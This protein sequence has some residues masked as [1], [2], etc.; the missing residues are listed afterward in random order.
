MP[1]PG[2]ECRA[3]SPQLATA[4]GLG[5]A[6]PVAAASARMPLAVVYQSVQNMLVWPGTLSHSR[7]YRRDKMACT[8]DHRGVSDQC[9]GH[10]CGGECAGSAL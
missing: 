4:A 10:V 5:T 8:V 7:M 9:G 1:M 6:G 3:G 2:R